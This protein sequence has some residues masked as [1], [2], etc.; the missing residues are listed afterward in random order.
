[1]VG[2]KPGARQIGL[3][4]SAIVLWVT[5]CQG[6]SYCFHRTN[7]GSASLAGA[8]SAQQAQFHD[9]APRHWAATRVVTYLETA[10]S[11]GGAPIVDVG[12]AM[13]SL[14]IRFE[15]PAMT[16]SFKLGDLGAVACAS[17]DSD[18]SQLVGSLLVRAV[19]APCGICA[20]GRLDADL[21][22]PSVVGTEGPQVSGTATLSYAESWSNP[23]GVC[24]PPSCS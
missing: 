9:R 14:A 10:T 6:P 20:C 11:D 7:E 13:V 8:E 18:C 19:A 4:A 22:I 16:G 1:M 12:P 15:R 3:V 21:T 17:E 24:W 23:G 2:G 5:G